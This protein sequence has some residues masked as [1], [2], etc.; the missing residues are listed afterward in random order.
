MER[1]A[2]TMQP[3]RDFARRRAAAIAANPSLQERELLKLAT[4]SAAAA[5]ALRGRGVP[6][7][8]ATLAADAGVAV[9]KVAFEQWIGDQPDFPACIRA[10]LGHLRTLT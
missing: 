1:A 2:E 3:R 4:L 9:F 10:T 7:P 8:A 6:E 5:E